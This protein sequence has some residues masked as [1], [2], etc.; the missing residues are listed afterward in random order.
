LK[1]LL[2]LVPEIKIEQHLAG[3]RPST[4]DARPILGEHQEATGIFIFNG[5]GSKGTSLAPLLTLQ[6]LNYLLEGT[7]FDSET[8]L[9]RFE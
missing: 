8:D 9:S 6:F 4:K 5:L 3:L 7:P 1:E 2:H